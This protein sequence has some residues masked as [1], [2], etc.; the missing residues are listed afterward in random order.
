MTHR[1][2]KVAAGAKEF[3]LKDSGKAVRTREE[4]SSKGIQLDQTIVSV[5]IKHHHRRVGRV[6]S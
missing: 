4:A 1:S 6:G 2:G 5:S 3:G